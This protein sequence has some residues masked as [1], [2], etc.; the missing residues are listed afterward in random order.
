MRLHAR[1]LI[2]AALAAVTVAAPA[3]RAQDTTP[4]RGVR[5]GLSYGNGTMP[6][7][8]VGVVRSLWGDSIQAIMQ[9]DLDAGDRVAVIGMPGT[10]SATAVTQVGPGINYVVWKTLAAAAAV[11]MSVANGALHVV[12][13]DVAKSAVLQT[14]DFPLPSTVGSAD[15]R[16]AVHAASDEVE[17]W[18]TGTRGIAATRVLYVAGQ[19][20]RLV[21][22]D[23][24]GDHAL[25][26]AGTTLSPAWHPSGAYFAYSALGPHGWRIEMQDLPTGTPRAL[27]SAPT[28]LNITPSFSADG[29]WLAYAHGDEEGVDL[30]VAPIASGNAAGAPRRVTVGRGTD[31]VSPSFSPEGHRLAFTSGRVGHPEVYLADVDGTNVEPLATD[32]SGE[33]VYRSNPDWSPDGRQIAFQQQINGVFQVMVITLRDRSVRQLTSEARNE[34]PSWAPD[35]RHLVFSTTRSG[36]RELFV[37]DAESGRAR[38][39]THGA[40]ARLPAWSPMLKTTP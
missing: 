40:G 35:G 28:G 37:L 19:H 27:G 31:N 39:L 5:L 38:Q 20:V 16:L 2:A 36:V 9:R 10:P 14:H 8:I 33:T 4:P 29:E 22:S 17:R 26:T 25:T 6:G 24:W 30:Y 15:W 3:L 18:I 21:D 7:V 23:G 13:H 11:Q 34:E 32:V 12:L 1:T